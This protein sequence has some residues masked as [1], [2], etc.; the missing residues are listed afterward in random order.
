MDFGIRKSK[1]V[2]N[3]RKHCFIDRIPVGKITEKTGT[4]NTVQHCQKYTPTDSFF[5]DFAHWV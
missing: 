1:P 2:T 3:T 5:G 4:Q